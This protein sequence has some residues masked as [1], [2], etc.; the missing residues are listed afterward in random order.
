MVDHG[1][2]HPGPQN[3]LLDRL[4][5]NWWL[6][7]ARGVAAIAF[8]VAALVWPSSALIALALVFGVYAFSDGALSIFA[9]FARND[10]NTAP[11]WWLIVAGFFGMAAGIITFGWP[12]ITATLLVVLMAIWAV[13]AGIVQMMGAFELRKELDDEWLLMIGG[14]IS[15]VA[16]L[17]VIAF[18][19][20]GALTLVTLIAVY[21]V[22]FGALWIVFAGR[23][24][25]MHA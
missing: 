24:R 4:S 20:I 16:G 8:G 2:I 5:R 7:L 10:V 13:L 23:L 22:I 3:S 25:N 18:P 14:L 19:G 21:A 17:F 6:L 15:I 9:A 12:G 11:T 1:A